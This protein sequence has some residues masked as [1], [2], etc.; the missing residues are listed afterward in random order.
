MKPDYQQDNIKLFNAD[1][2]DIMKGYPD[3]H[4]DLILSDPPYGTTACKWDSI[5][6]IDEMWI[7]LKRLIKPG[8]AIILLSAQPFTSFL[9]QSN[10]DGFKYETIYEK[11][12]P[13]GFLSS[14]LR[15]LTAHENIL[16]FGDAKTYNPE[17][18]KIPDYLI[19]KRKHATSKRN[20]EVYGDGES[21][22]WIDSGVRHP[23]SVIGF[24]NHSSSKNI[25]PTQKPLLLMEYLI[26]TYSNESDLVLD[27][28][29]GSGTTGLAAHKLK[30]KFVGIELDTEYY[31][32]AK[33]RIYNETRQLDLL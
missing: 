25:H 2:L 10:L 29:F 1:C 22:R 21:K 20:G 5:I 9:I 16:L 15:P 6:P 26:K 4:F 17:M 31:E 30:R 8:G 27:F 18:W 13:K 32:S 23:T 14:K 28:C 33:K 3:D 7:N 12:N 19:T 11:T 24:S